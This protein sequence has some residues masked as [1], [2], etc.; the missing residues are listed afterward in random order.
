[1]LWGQ[2]SPELQNMHFV[3]CPAN[4]SQSYPVGLGELRPLQPSL[5]G[6]QERLDWKAVGKAVPGNRRLALTERAQLGQGVAK[7]ARGRS[8]FLHAQPQIGIGD[9]DAGAQQDPLAPALR[10]SRPHGLE[11]L[12]RLPE[13]TA[14]V[15]HDAVAQRRMARR[16]VAAKCRR[17]QQL[18]LRERL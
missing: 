1:M 18:D 12:A 2:S 4:G 9:Q 7:Q 5:Q 11:D 16:Y 15:E 8:A 10:S 3:S 14:I 6:C 17:H 13:V